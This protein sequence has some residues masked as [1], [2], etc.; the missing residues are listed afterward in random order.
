MNNNI[1]FLSEIINY[2]IL[3][4]ISHSRDFCLFVCLFVGSKKSYSR[5]MDSRMTVIAS[6]SGALT[7]LIAL[8]FILAT[9]YQTTKSR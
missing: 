4:S 5:P 2:V 7:A 8:V 3:D 1:R 9:K 6:V